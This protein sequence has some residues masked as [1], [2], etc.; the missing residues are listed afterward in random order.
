MNAPTHLECFAH[1][2]E[3]LIYGL[4]SHYTL[5]LF[6]IHPKVNFD[7]PVVLSNLVTRCGTACFP[8]KLLS[9]LSDTV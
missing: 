6:Q 7:C 3:A 2:L 5:I 4:F 9:T 8:K 1:D